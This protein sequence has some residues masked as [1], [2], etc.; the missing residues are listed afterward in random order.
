MIAQRNR[1]VR[2]GIAL[3]VRVE[4]VKICSE[5]NQWHVVWTEKKKNKF[6]SF[7]SLLIVTMQNK[8]IISSRSHGVRYRNERSKCKNGQSTCILSFPFAYSIIIEKI[9]LLI[10]SVYISSSGYVESDYGYMCMVHVESYFVICF[11]NTHVICS[12]YQKAKQN[13]T[14]C[15]MQTSDLY[16]YPFNQWIM[17]SSNPESIKSICDYIIQIH[18]YKIR[19]KVLVAV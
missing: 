3:L 15:M 10:L 5:E 4:L 11:H 19:K 12:T 17:I 9:G 18:I 8:F 16:V 1:G 13:K 14:L 2:F 6:I 7:L